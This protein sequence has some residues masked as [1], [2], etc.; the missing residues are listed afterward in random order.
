M[1]YTT[2]QHYGVCLDVSYDPAQRTLTFNDLDLTQVAELFGSI[3]TS[4]ILSSSVNDLH[5]ELRNQREAVSE[6]ETQVQDLKTSYDE[7]TQSIAYWKAEAAKPSLR[8]F[9]TTHINAAILGMAISGQK[10]AAIKL[11][12]EFNSPGIGLKEAKDY[13]EYLHNSYLAHMRNTV[14]CTNDMRR[15]IA[16]VSGFEVKS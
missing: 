5:Y 16:E 15:I 9:S 4:S 7:A 6:L 11:W 2:I 12:R 8:T 3:A 13:V 1:N 10:I 14:G